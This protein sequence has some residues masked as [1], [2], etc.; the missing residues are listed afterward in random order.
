MKYAEVLD[1]G[2]VTI[3]GYEATPENQPDW[4]S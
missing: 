4:Q 3:V 1:F 2:T